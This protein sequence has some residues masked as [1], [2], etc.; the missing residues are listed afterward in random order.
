MIP[1]EYR[2]FRAEVIKRY[3]GEG[4]SFRGGG[5]SKE[6][7]MRSDSRFGKNLKEQGAKK[8]LEVAFSHPIKLIANA[9]GVPPK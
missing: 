8:L 7:E 4:E 6:K 5:D 9:L 1:Q 3:D 2:D